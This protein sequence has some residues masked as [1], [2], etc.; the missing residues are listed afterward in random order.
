MATGGSPR[1]LPGSEPD[2]E[3]ILSWQQLYDLPDLPEHLVVVGSG[4]TGAEFASAYL[5]LGSKVTLVSSRDRVLPSEDA[6]AALLLEDVFSRRGMQIM[7]RSRAA[8]ITRTGSGVVVKLEDGG[9]VEGTHCLVAVGALPNTNGLGLDE[10]PV[11][12][13]AAV[14]QPG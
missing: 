9:T 10:A 6:D 2:G 11:L 5:A 1:A 8:S 12:V 14:H 4:V 7:K 3:R 13:I